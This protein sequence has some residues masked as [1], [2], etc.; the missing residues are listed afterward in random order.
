MTPTCRRA[1]RACLPALLLLS[2]KVGAGGTAERPLIPV[3]ADAAAVNAACAEGQNA[4]RAGIEALAA[5]PLEQAAR[6]ETLHRWDE[7]GILFDDVS[8]PLAITSATHPDKAVRDAAEACELELSKLQTGLYQNAAIHQ[9]LLRTEPDTAAGRQVRRV[10]LEGFEDAGVTLG[11]QARARAKEIFDR[12]DAL[13]MEFQ[14]NTRENLGTVSMTVAELEGMPQSYR[15]A[16][17]ADAEGRVTLK[18]NYPDFVPFMDNAVSAEAR[19]RYFMAF[20]RIGGERNLTILD[21]ATKLRRELAGLFGK[22]SYAHQIISRRMAGTPEKVMAF[23][24]SVRDKVAAVE[25]RDL[26]VLRQAK[27]DLLGRPLAEVRIERWDVSFYIERVRRA[28]HAVDQDALRRYFPTDASVSWL[29]DLAQRMFGVRFVAAQVPVW[30]PDVRYYDILDAS[31]RRIAGAY[32]DLYPRDGKYNHAAVWGL[33]G[34]S[35]RIG[36]TPTSVLVANLNRQGLD[37]GELETLLHEFG[38]LLHG[39]LSR[40]EYNMLAG[41]GVRRDFV[42]APSQM[43]EE[44]ARRP[45]SVALIRD[46]CKDCPLA[47]AE[48][49]QRINAAKRFGAGLHYSRQHLL[50][51]FDMA[52]AGAQPGEGLATYRALEEATPLGHVPGTMF[53]ARFGHL[54]GGYAAGYYGYMWSEVI[55]LDMASQW[56]GRLLDEKVSRRYLDKLLSRGGETPPEELVRDFLGREPSPE[57]FFAEITG[58]RHD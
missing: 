46:H 24:D 29:T 3:Y 36:R 20:N 16:H 10:A 35:T 34:A 49:L 48:L 45:Q 17:P 43:L 26:E 13:G 42:E 25:R 33:R 27:A 57:P 4:A 51:V 41:T 54:L 8:G 40:T 7:L 9:R 2:A 37:H 47:D 12:L 44:W 50:A 1:L 58:S 32:F 38:H 28:R 23:L 55:A 14:R 15:D 11:E 22:A 19:R 30:H 6:P 18:M 21:E 39:T 5:L 52:M 31:G 53:P 56:R